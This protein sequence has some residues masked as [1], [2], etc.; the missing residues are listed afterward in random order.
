MDECC[1]S[2]TRRMG[3]SHVW[4]LALGVL[5]VYGYHGMAMDASSPP[6]RYSCLAFCYLDVCSQTT[7]S[8]ECR[9]HGQGLSL[10]Y[11]TV[12][13]IALSL[14]VAAAASSPASCNAH[15]FSLYPSLFFTIHHIHTS[16]CLVISSIMIL[17]T[18]TLLKPYSLS[19]RR[20]TVLYRRLL[21]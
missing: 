21:I 4:G 2:G 8:Y 14:S 13:Y 6:I 9:L 7:D 19:L 1:F 17:L 16:H 20:M 11:S 10:C 15:H 5:K 18:H 12:C 3:R